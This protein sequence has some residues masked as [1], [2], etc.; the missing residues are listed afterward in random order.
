[1]A[2]RLEYLVVQTFCQSLKNSIAIERL[3]PF[4][5]SRRSCERAMSF[6][7]VFTTFSQLIFTLKTVMMAHTARLPDHMVILFMNNAKECK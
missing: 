5:P 3:Q 6:A 7:T 2:W 1:M 4:P